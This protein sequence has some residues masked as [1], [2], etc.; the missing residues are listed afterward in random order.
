MTGWLWRRKPAEPGRVPGGSMRSAASTGQV[1]LPPLGVYCLASGLAGT[2]AGGAASLLFA[3]TA[4]VI[5]WCAVT[6]AIS[7]TA[8]I[9]Y[10]A[11]SGRD[12]AVAGDRAGKGCRR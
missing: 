10:A 3:G 1:P 7:I 5:T 8:G 11:D 4:R 9:V 6:A 2:G 12:A